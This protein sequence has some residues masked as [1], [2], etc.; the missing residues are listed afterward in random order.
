M[1]ELPEVE[2]A[3]A[4]LERSALHR[5]VVDVDDVCRAVWRATAQYVLR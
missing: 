5:T 2:S 3:R 4:V 1:P